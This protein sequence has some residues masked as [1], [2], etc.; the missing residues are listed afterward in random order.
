MATP[1]ASNMKSVPTP[2]GAKTVAHGR[3]D[4]PGWLPSLTYT[5]RLLAKSGRPVEMGCPNL[6]VTSHCVCYFCGNCTNWSSAGSFAPGTRCA[7]GSHE[8][9]RGT[10]RATIRWGAAP[11]PASCH[12]TTP[13]AGQRRWRA[14]SCPTSPVP[15]ATS[16]RG[17]PNIGTPWLGERDERSCGI[18][19]PERIPV[20]T[21]TGCK[22]FPS[23]SSSP[24]RWVV[25]LVVLQVR[26]RA[27]V[28]VRAGYGVQD[29]AGARH[30]PAAPQ[31]RQAPL[32]QERTFLPTRTDVVRWTDRHPFT[33][34]PQPGEECFWQLLRDRGDGHIG[35]RAVRRRPAV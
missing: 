7:A 35:R 5:R 26:R 25:T 1:A 16:T 27:A 15:R 17:G 31:P 21:W 13:A 11:P 19:K 3:Q 32:A 14:W 12:C 9:H 28:E 33:S 34:D 2:N 24:T 18:H 30:A 20:F 6:V 4:A 8:A 22:T 10:A 29:A 23:S